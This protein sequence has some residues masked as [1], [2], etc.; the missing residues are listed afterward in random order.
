[1]KRLDRRTLLRGAG[2]V[3]IA[4][5]FLDAMWGGHKAWAQGAPRRLC[6]MTGQNGVVR[7]A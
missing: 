5:P 4:L 1:M 3:G 6:V 7:G 2:G